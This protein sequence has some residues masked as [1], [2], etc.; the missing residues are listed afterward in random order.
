MMVL[1]SAGAG[2]SRTVRSFVGSR[3]KRVRKD[4]EPKLHKARL[5]AGVKVR[6]G[7]QQSGGRASAAKPAS[8]VAEMLGV[9]REE[10]AAAAIAVDAVRAEHAR[11]RQGVSAAAA[12]PDTLKKLQ[13]ELEEQVRNSCLLAAPT[14]CASFQL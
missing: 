14:G 9:P 10:A 1:G 7:P 8:N 2:K 4:F 13:A 3:R 5:A 12:Q 11:S 6:G